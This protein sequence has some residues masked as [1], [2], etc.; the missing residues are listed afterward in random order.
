MHGYKPAGNI[1][2]VLESSELKH[3]DTS[4]LRIKL[5]SPYMRV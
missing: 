1:K 3:N 4:K 5:K 2:E